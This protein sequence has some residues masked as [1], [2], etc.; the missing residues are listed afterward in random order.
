LIKPYNDQDVYLFT[1]GEKRIFSRTK[2]FES[3]SYDLNQVVT[4]EQDIFDF[5][6]TG[7]PMPFREGALLKGTKPGVFLIEYGKKREFCSQESYL[8]LGYSWSSIILVSDEILNEIERGEDIC[9][10][11]F[12]PSGTL[13]KTE[14][15]PYIYLMTDNYKYRYPTQEHFL[16][17]GYEMEQVIT[18]SEAEME[19][20]PAGPDISFRPGT[21]LKGSSEAVYVMVEGKKHPF[22]GG[23]IF[24]AYGFCSGNIT[25]IADDVLATVPTSDIL[26]FSPLELIVTGTGGM[27]YPTPDVSL[28]ISKNI[29]QNPFR[30]NYIQY[31]SSVTVTGILHDSGFAYELSA[32]Y[33]DGTLAQPTQPYTV[34]LT[35]NQDTL[36]A[37][38]NENTLALY[39]W[40]N[41]RWVRESTSSVDTVANTITAS[42]AR[43][44]LFAILAQDK[45]YLPIILK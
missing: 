37:Q 45:I 6:P 19:S 43:F 9:S 17:W 20:Y 15:N 42:P 23:D 11:D 35:Y 2:I 44:G 22:I 16:S 39:V 25:I 27:Y 1:N 33:P 7:E 29:S 38:V 31:T 40:E 3:Y 28:T 12:R 30:L 26:T 18:I 36:P 4:V 21:L 13:I 41:N 8:G 24:S 14:N 32:T 5:I 34:T 10:T